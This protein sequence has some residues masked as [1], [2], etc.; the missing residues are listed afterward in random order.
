MRSAP[1]GHVPVGRF[2]SGEVVRRIFGPDLS[3]GKELGL[4][5]MLERVHRGAGARLVAGL[6]AR[7]LPGTG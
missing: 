7:R 6:V 4:L 1:S 5:G 2:V 3:M